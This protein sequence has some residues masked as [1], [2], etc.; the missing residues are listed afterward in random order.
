MIPPVNMSLNSPKNEIEERYHKATDD[1]ERRIDLAHAGSVLFCSVAIFCFYHGAFIVG[2]ILNA[3]GV[4]ICYHASEM[5]G[6]CRGFSEGT[7]KTMDICMEIVRDIVK[8][9]T[10]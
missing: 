5:K 8:K 10:K 2:V 7:D 9:V 6:W 4:F 3:V 1:L